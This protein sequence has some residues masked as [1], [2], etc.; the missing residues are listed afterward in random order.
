MGVGRWVWVWS[1]GVLESWTRVM[2]M[3]MV[4]VVFVCWFGVVR[5]VANGIIFRANRGD[6]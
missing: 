6:G 3:A 1:L 5:G 2:V 4:D